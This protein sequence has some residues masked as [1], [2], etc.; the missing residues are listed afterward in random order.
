MSTTIV[1]GES[2]KYGHYGDSEWCGKMRFSV[3]DTGPGIA[4]NDIARIFLPFERLGAERTSVEG[5]GIGLSLCKRL[6]E[7]MNGDIGVESV[8][9]IGSTFWV[10]L[11]LVAAD[12]GMRPALEEPTARTD[13][14]LIQEGQEGQ[15]M[16]ED[17]LTILYI[18][19]NS[20]NFAVIKHAFALQRRAIDLLEAEQGSVGL[21]LARSHQPDLIFLDLHL[22][23]IMG[24]VVL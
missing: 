1:P 18:E 15:D 20:S 3:R 19:D 16:P 8:R 17:A 6:V 12:L 5:T 22:P 23:D 4:P 10:E 13:A 7:A 24:D 2:V 14:A 11:P 9:G 21:D